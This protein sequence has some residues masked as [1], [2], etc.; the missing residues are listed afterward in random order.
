MDKEKVYIVIPVFNHAEKLGEVIQSLFSYGYHRIIVVNDGSTDRTF[1]QRLPSPICYLEH[2]VNLGQ[3]AALQT[4]FDLALE[5]GA[6]VV[7]SFDADGQHEASDIGPLLAP[8]L[9]DQADVSMGSRF[10]VTG[11]AEAPLS[12]TVLLKTAR[13]IN[14]LFTGIMLT[15]AHNGLR[16][17][18]RKALG[19]I[20]ITENRMAHATEILFEIR[21]HEL[22]FREV[23]V[24]IRYTEYSRSTGQS[25]WNSI[26]IFFDILLYKLFA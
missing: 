1:Q 25:A 8:V 10:L 6:D 9:A 13:V 22:R 7:V 15:D 18:N 17:I 24:H 4:G 3:G 23:P 14:Y 12:R 11:E 20:R 5:R 2:R 19:K 16:A 21:K 26:R